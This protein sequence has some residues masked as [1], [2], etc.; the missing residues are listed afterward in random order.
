MID[1]S[2]CPALD[3]AFQLG[4]AKKSREMASVVAKRLGLDHEQ[5]IDAGGLKV[6]CTASFAQ[7]RPSDS[8]SLINAVNCWSLVKLPWR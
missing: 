8:A 6:Q 7:T 1:L 3:D 5:R 2:N 4:I